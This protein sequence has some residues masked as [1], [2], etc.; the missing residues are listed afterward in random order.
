[1]DDAMALG[2]VDLASAG[3]D[4]LARRGLRVASYDRTALAGRVAHLGVGGFHR[5]HLA[6][7][8]HQLA[9]EHGST[10]AIRGLGVLASDG[11][12][13][14]ALEHQQGRYTL[15]SRDNDG[16]TVEVIESLLDHTWAPPDGDP[17]SVIA[18]L[19]DPEV[20]IV[21]MTITES[22]YEEGGRAF[23]LLAAALDARRRSDAGPVTVVS[24]DNLPGNG[25]AARRCTLA[26]AELLGAETAAWVD[27]ECSFPSSMVD[28]ITPATT[29]ADRDWLVTEY[30][31][32][33]RWPVVAEP[34]VQWVLEDTFVAGRPPFEQAGVLFSTTVDDWEQYKLRL[35]NAAHSAMAYLC[36]LA[37][38]TYVHDA[39]RDVTVR[40][41]L[42]RLTLDEAA[43]SLRRIT[44]HPPEEYARVALDRFTNGAIADTLARLCID[45]TAKFPK[46]LV[47]TLRH[48][49][50][51]DGPID[52]AVLAL[53]GWARY[54]VEW[55]AEQQA[56]DRSIAAARR[57]AEAA[58]SDPACF[59]D[60]A[61]VFP[62]ELR[63][64]RLRER[65]T[66]QYR[67]VAESPMAT[68]AAYAA[69]AR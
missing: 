47:P 36:T 9:E 64:E 19:A 60:F 2:V 26:A 32:A 57:Y 58:R 7:Y 68:L 46:F 66:A 53:A 65:F 10:W 24:C 62:P 1:T 34:F 28:R 30:G 63:T 25:A 22:G 5:S 14:A 31:V 42:D 51:S 33:D 20:A 45:G 27:G 50:E 40:A 29:A 39:V 21:S 16:A 8:L 69:G 37:G 43:P 15:I 52:G 11:E 61:A 48:H 4:D 67:A 44:G 55:P 23:A 17:A 41:F 13:N 35:L 6:Y 3:R 54:L 56:H 38:F 12:I 59:V 18:R 49:L